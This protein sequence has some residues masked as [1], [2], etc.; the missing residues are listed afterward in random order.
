M[1]Q[2]L[3]VTKPKIFSPALLLVLF[4]WMSVLLTA[5]GVIYSTYDTRLKVNE[6]SVLRHQKDEL[7]VMWGQYLLEES[8][9]A[10]YGRVEK[11]A[12]EKLLMQ[13]PSNQQIITVS[14]DES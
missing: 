10:S 14:A 12:T 13:V 4:L 8:T 3:K 2:S 6:I 11:I 5:L 1:N 9:W 7:Q